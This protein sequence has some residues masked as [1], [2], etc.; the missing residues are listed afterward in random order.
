MNWAGVHQKNCIWYLRGDEKKK[1]KKKKKKKSARINTQEE[2]SQRLLFINSK[3][4]FLKN[5]FK[6]WN[7]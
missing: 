2:N 7:D 5:I 3:K 1:K 6:D 4:N